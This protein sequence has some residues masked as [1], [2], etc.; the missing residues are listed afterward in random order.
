MD[1]RPI[2]AV[3]ARLLRAAGRLG[4]GV[5]TARMR[6]PAAR[7][8]TLGTGRIRGDQDDV[9]VAWRTA[10]LRGTVPAGRR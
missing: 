8:A 2:A 9:M 10:T 4:G 1:S 7:D 6:P 5:I 3:V